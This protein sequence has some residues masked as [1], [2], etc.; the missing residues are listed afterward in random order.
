[1]GGC[2]V[3]EFLPFD[4]MKLNLFKNSYLRNCL[5]RKI[6]VRAICSYLVD[7]FIDKYCNEPP[8]LVGLPKSVDKPFSFVYSETSKKS[9]VI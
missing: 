5:L 9:L 7:F 6:D 2:Y 8:E 3:I 4:L 1:M